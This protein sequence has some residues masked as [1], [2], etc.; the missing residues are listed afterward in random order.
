VEVGIVSR[1]GG[2]LESSDG[3]GALVHEDLF[4]I[5]SLD[6]LRLRFVRETDGSFR[7]EALYND[8]RVLAC[9]KKIL[10]KSS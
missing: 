4:R 7:L 5:E 10:G 1:V 6:S 9:S 8:G 2:G 3:E